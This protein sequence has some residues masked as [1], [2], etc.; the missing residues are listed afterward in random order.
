MYYE[1]K[2]FDWAN[3][4]GRITFATL[5]DYDNCVGSVRVYGYNNAT[6]QDETLFA[7]DF[8]SHAE[9]TKALRKLRESAVFTYLFWRICDMLLTYEDFVEL[10]FDEIF[11]LD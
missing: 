10:K 8:T 9:R 7:E 3:L 4:Q 6:R 11:G 5:E 1:H 2:F